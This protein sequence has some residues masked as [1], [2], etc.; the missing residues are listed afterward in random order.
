M[1]IYSRV[2]CSQLMSKDACQ[3]HKLGCSLTSCLFGVLMRNECVHVTGFHAGV[4]NIIAMPWAM[5]LA[6][7]SPQ[8]RNVTRSFALAPQESRQLLSVPLGELLPACSSCDAAAEYF[9]LLHAR[10]SNGSHTGW[11]R[12]QASR[13]TVSEQL[14][15]AV[16][17][18]LQGGNEVDAVARAG[19]ARELHIS[20]Q[21]GAFTIW[22]DGFSQSVGQ[23]WLTEMK[24]AAVPQSPGVR[25]THMFQVA[26]NLLSLHVECDQVA[27]MVYIDAWPLPGRF[28]DNLFTCIPGV[29]KRLTFDAPQTEDIAMHEL[30]D[31]LVVMHM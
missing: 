14:A 4:V 6:P 15:A 19:V 7:D 18:W 12:Q 3:L 11:L 23:V 29:A 2:A 17:P 27:V 21:G 24:D 26:H 13:E 25:V 8:P 31:K 16:A 30:D 5:T 28:S 22:P 10:A 9:V 20:E 1:V